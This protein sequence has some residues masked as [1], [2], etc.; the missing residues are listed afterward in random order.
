MG[1]LV[2]AYWTFHSNIFVNYS[3]PLVVPL[4]GGPFVSLVSACAEQRWCCRRE[5]GE[6]ALAAANP[7]TAPLAGSRTT[8]PT[9]GLWP[10]VPSCTT[11]LQDKL[12][13]AV[14]EQQALILSI[15]T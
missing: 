11:P 6:G 4:C 2:T 10:P 8:L 3:M 7:G 1:Q 14:R 9:R 12:N 13:E 15:L 5:Q